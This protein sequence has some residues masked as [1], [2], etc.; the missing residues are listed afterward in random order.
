MTL[1]AADGSNRSGGLGWGS[2]RWRCKRARSV[3]DAA[4]DLLGLAHHRA[5]MSTA[6]EMVT[7]KATPMIA[8]RLSGSLLLRSA[9]TR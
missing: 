2:F 4:A 5:M 8:G 7:I 3:P 1:V 9:I 6:A